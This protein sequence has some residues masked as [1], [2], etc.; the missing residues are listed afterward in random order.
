MGSPEIPMPDLQPWSLISGF[1]GHSGL[2][3][4]A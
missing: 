3:A 4:K 2:G 1:L